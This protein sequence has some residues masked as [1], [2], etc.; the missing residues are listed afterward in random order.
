MHFGF[1][2]IGT[3]YTAEFQKVPGSSPN[4]SIG[5]KNVP[6]NADVQKPKSATQVYKMWLL[7]SLFPF[8]VF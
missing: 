2:N 4:T 1:Q 7:L 8:L 6:Q 3:L 5:L